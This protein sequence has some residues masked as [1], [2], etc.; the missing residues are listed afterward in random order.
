MIRFV[1]WYWPS[2]FPL[3]FYMVNNSSVTLTHF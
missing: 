3:P 2:E 1:V